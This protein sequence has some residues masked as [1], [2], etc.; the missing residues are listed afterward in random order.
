M[1]N[2]T[3]IAINGFGRIGRCVLRVLADRPAFKNGECE[4]V[5]INDL[6]TPETLAY[7]FKYDSVHGPF[8]GN[9][10]LDGDKLVVNG[11]PIPI[12]SQPD[13]NKLPW[14]KVG[15]DIILECTGKFK[16]K[17]DASKHLELGAKKVVISAPAKDPDIT[18]VM[19]VNDG[20]YDH[21]KHHVLSNASCTTNCLA[22][23]AKVLH[24]NFKIR[25]GFMT[26]IH[27]YTND[28]RLLDLP[29]S[30][31]R[32]A[33]AAC[34]S[35]I[36]TTTGAAKAVGLVLPEL[37]GKVDGLSIRVPTPNVSLVDFV[38]NVEK[39]TTKEAV[40]EK[41]REAA[42]GKLKG[43]LKYMDEP[44]VSI[45][46]NGSSYSSIVDADQTGVIEGNLIKVMSWYDN[47]M[48]FSHRM[49]ELMMKMAERGYKS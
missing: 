38:C 12:L 35:M 3:R 4:V 23:V 39:T 44:C 17:S 30:D 15:A 16:G 45:D 36:P 27:S 9:A 41:L 10:V 19:G 34:L 6:T 31:L 5:A 28:Q 21:A 20:A 25:N 37:K 22:P 13:V 43:I 32:R 18:I 49:V 14:A 47:E 11:R 2:S 40:N 46:F 26:T 42:E 24:E 29:H 1:G 33:R 8:K 48:G 7:L